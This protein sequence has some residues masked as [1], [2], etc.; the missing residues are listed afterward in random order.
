[1]TGSTEVAS[2]RPDA[3]RIALVVAR[4]I[5]DAVEPMTVTIGTNTVT[6]HVRREPTIDWP[7]RKPFNVD[8]SVDGSWPPTV[9]MI[10]ERSEG[11]F[12]VVLVCRTGSGGTYEGFVTLQALFNARPI[13]VFPIANRWL[14]AADGEV[15]E[16]TAS[17]KL[18]GGAQ[19]GKAPSAAPLRS[20]LQTLELPFLNDT[21]VR[22]GAVRIPDATLTE[23]ASVVAS[24]FVNFALRK[25]PFLVDREATAPAAVAFR[26]LVDRSETPLDADSTTS[27][28][29]GDAPRKALGIWPLPGGVRQ[30]KQTLDALLE[31]FSQEP[32]SDEDFRSLMLERFEAPGKQSVPAYLT[33]IRRLG[34]LVERDGRYSL[35]GAGTDYL[36]E[37]SPLVLFD[38]LADKYVGILEMIVIVDAGVATSLRATNEQ[39]MAL[40]DHRWET[41]TQA[42]FRRNWLLSLGLVEAGDDRDELTPRGVEALAR[43]K[44][45][46]ERL[47][48]AI[49]PEAA[50]TD[51]L[52][53][54]SPEI[55]GS[56][57]PTAVAPMAEAANWA[58]DR[59]DLRAEHA[60]RALEHLELPSTLLDRACA[61]LSAGKHLLLVGP[62]GTGKTE[63]AQA[64]ALAAEREGY[65]SS[66]HAVT[67]SADWTTF[68]T[69]GGYAL[70]RDNS[71]QFRPGAL[72][73]AI[74]KR[75]WLLIDELNRADVD[76][77]FGELMTV[78]SG[79][80]VETS[81]E[82]TDGR[83]ISI[84]PKP[85]CTHVV[86]PVFRVIATMNSWDKSSLFR[87][88]FA[89]QRRFAVLTVDVPT[90]EALAKILRRH[91]LEIRLGRELDP[92]TIDRLSELW[93]SRGL[94]R[95]RKVGPAVM[96]DLVRYLRH[97]DNGADAMAEGLAMFV[98]PQLA[99]LDDSDARLVVKTLERAIGVDASREARRE[100]K[101]RVQELFVGTD[102]GDD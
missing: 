44:S 65:C 31:W 2:V 16:L 22:L 51:A 61:A 60:R 38:A 28:L 39:L 97:R 80:S 82:T 23:P 13:V 73:R 84:G 45:E 101:E 68:D 59:L 79:S 47:R 88:S 14:R 9:R 98:L 54:E 90:D 94:L 33:L 42:S 83:R 99:G 58:A 1:M 81:F 5:L 24:R 48:D 56:D 35:S 7:E 10:C 17:T 34:F 8:E 6:V 95:H 26:S 49:D 18:F 96:I 25:G 76:K 53:E 69:I 75:Q 21:Q 4:T 71:L 57:R 40:I 43:H 50:E 72:V 55:E 52:P 30:Y 20:L 86:T 70:Q 66:L 32:R 74:E 62:P 63:L 85:W 41:T 29:L 64:L 67:A 37:R 77:A 87:L 36:R 100:F 46:V 3:N 91:A 78:L 27:D 102:L 92:D 19:K 12:E 93:S 89:V 11:T 15:C